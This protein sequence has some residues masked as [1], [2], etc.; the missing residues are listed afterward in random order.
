M[1]TSGLGRTYEDGEAIVRQGEVGDRMF[2]I[3]EGQAQVSMEKEGQ[4]KLLRVAREG[5]LIGEMAVFEKQVRSATVRALGRTRVLTIDKKSVL[6]RISED[7]SIA[8]RVV[9][10]MSRRGRELSDEVARLRGESAGGAE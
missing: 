5:E 1:S 10:T 3:Q 2:V 8:F 7:P 9:Q 6:R 4:E